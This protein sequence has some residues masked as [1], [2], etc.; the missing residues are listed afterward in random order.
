[1][2]AFAAFSELAA[3]VMGILTVRS[4]RSRQAL[5]RPVASVPTRSRTGRVR[6]ASKTSTVAVLVGAGQHD[7]AAAGALGAHPGGHLA[8]RGNADHRP[9]EQRA[10]AG[11]DRPG[12]VDVGRVAGHDDPVRAE[13]VGRADDAADVARAGRAVQQDAEE[14]RSGRD[15]VQVVRWHLDHGDQLRRARV[16]LAEFGQQAGRHGDLEGGHVAQHGPRPARQRALG[17]VEQRAER[18]AELGRQRDRPDALDQE[19]AVP[20]ALAPVAEQRLPLLEPGVPRRDPKHPVSPGRRPAGRGGRAAA[21]GAP[22]RR[23][24]GRAARDTRPR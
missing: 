15:P 1:M 23:R 16:L 24:P 4:H 22:P 7:R 10:G 2:A 19:L 5:L 9:G 14:A 12:V 3:P 18:P 21:R 13:G 11:P 6:S 8:V 20:L 17:V